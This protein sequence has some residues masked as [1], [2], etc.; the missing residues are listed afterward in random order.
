MAFI[1]YAQAFPDKMLV[2]VDTY[3]TLMSGVPNFLCVALALDDAGFQP[4]GVRLDSGDLAYLSRQVRIIFDDMAANY[5]ERQSLQS[6]KIA[7]SNDIN[8]S[9]LNSLNEQGH[10]CDIFG[11]GTNLITCQ[12]QPALGMV[13]KLVELKG[14][15]RI[16]LSEEMEKVSI[17]G[18]KQLFR[19]YS[20]D[21][22]PILD[23]MQRASD[24]APEANK[25][26]FCRH[27]LDDTKR[28]YVVPSRVEQLL[29]LVWDGKPTGPMPTLHESREFSLRRVLELREDHLRPMNPTPYKVSVSNSFFEF[30]RNIWHESAPV[31]EFS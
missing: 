2:L 8:E 21:H 12:S 7:A 27:I 31:R 24:E 22:I 19:L 1:R 20:K 6:L 29:H 14:Q 13:Y 9:V 28:C 26:I 18:R 5:P 23:L 15:P 25:K 30:F 11:I 17:P 4:V 10:S 16:K 3:D